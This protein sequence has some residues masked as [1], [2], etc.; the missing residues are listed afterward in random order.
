M[1]G[2]SANHPLTDVGEDVLQRDAGIVAGVVRRTLT[3]R[4]EPEPICWVVVFAVNWTKNGSPGSTASVAGASPD[5]CCT[6]M[7]GGPLLEVSSLAR[8]WLVCST[9]KLKPS[10]SA[11]TATVKVSASL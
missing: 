8:N 5:S 4:V 3:S 6:T 7:F 2:K 9:S 10:T 11:S 1:S